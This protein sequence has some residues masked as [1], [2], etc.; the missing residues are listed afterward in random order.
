MRYALSTYFIV[1]SR[2]GIRNHFSEFQV[3]VVVYYQGYYYNVFMLLAQAF[4]H[5]SM[6]VPGL[7]INHIRV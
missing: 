2:G 4:Q 7:Y 5:E 6:C 1:D 3:T